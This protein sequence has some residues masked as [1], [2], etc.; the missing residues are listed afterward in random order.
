MKEFYDKYNLNRKNETTKPT[1]LVLLFS[2][3]Y[4]FYIINLII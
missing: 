4:Y 1:L 2:N 3:K